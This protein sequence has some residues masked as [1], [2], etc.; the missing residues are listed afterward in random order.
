VQKKE[1]KYPG[2]GNQGGHRVSQ[3]V[4][5]KERENKKGALNDTLRK[6]GGVRSMKVNRER[7]EIGKRG[8]AKAKDGGMLS[9]RT[10]GGDRFLRERAQKRGREEDNDQR[11]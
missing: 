8:D 9:I 2:W 7:P 4:E 6:S 11:S 1:A 5:L 10:V 3:S